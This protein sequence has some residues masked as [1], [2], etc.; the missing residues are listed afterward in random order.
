[1]LE[2]VGGVEGGPYSLIL[3]RIKPQP[4]HPDLLLDH[5]SLGCACGGRA[6]GDSWAG[7]LWDLGRVSSSEQGCFLPAR[8][9]R[10]WVSPA[11]RPAEPLP[12]V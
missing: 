9:G 4:W 11:Q 8:Q 10:L 5:C 6:R 2:R 1:M 12:Q 7:G 3:I